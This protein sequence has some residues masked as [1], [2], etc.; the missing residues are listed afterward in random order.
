MTKSVWFLDYD[1]SLC[2]HQEAWEERA[3][4]PEDIVEILTQLKRQSLGAYWNTGR[5]IESLGGI[6]TKFLDTSGYFVHGSVFWNSEEKTSKILSPHLPADF[7][8]NTQK[9]L[10]AHKSLRL[11][12]KETSMRIAPVKLQDLEHVA[13]LMPE[14]SQIASNKDWHWTLGHRGAELLAKS[15]NK[16]FALKEV[17]SFPDM[18]K[19]IPVVIGDDVLDRP[20]VEEAFKHNGFAFL[21]GDGCGWVT[22]IPHQPW[23]VI[24]CEHPKR[25]HD[26]ILKLL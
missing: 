8:N 13:V 25:V 19:S 14:L 17:L 1:G 26:L 16:S 24:F 18:K 6:H 22:E 4:N 10:T 20:A 7:K 3:Y 12:I 2:P 21:V 9:L 5:R 15:F 23:Q 11:E